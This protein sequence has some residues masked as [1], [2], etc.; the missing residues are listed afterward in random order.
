MPVICIG[1]VCIP[2]NM[3]LPFVLGVLHR[4]GYLNWIK[5]E[6][7]TFTFWR[8]H[9]RRCVLTKNRQT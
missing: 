8:A 9:I 4:Y 5:R 6:W 3:F 1:P 2:L 7:V